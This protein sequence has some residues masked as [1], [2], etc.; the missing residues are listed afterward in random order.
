M[1]RRTAIAIP[2]YNDNDIENI[3]DHVFGNLEEH[4][5]GKFEKID[6]RVKTAGDGS[7]EILTDDNMRDRDVYII[8]PLVAD[9]AKHVLIAQE[10]SD[11]LYRSDAH[12]VFLFDLYNPYYSYD[13]R[14]KK[15]SLNARVV[16][17]NY[18]SSNIKRVFTFEPHSQMLVLAF[19]VDCPL[20]P[21]PMQ[22]HLAEHF[23]QRYD[24]SNITVCSPD[25]G[26]YKRAEVFADLLQVPL[27]GLRK[28]RSVEKSDATTPLGIVGDIK[29]VKGKMILFRD[30]VIRSAGSIIGAMRLLDDAG[31]AGYYVVVTHLSLCGEARQRIK[32]NKITVI[33]TN[34]IPQEFDE[35]EEKIYSIFDVSPLTSEIIYRR[36]DALSIG[37]YFKSF[38]RKH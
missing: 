31:A 15:Q 38:E 28:I 17:D 25:I 2:R 33:G 19:S 37:K 18:A 30:D 20:E 27:I 4:H 3:G 12:K 1:Y 35:S 21:L 8:H 9:P 34:T 23:R 6:L 26:G 22:L 13:Q 32:D 24:L 14:K 36:S 29:N 16:A 11:N 10:I 5:P 7:E